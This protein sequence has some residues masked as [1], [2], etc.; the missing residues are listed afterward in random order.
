MPP[1]L[2]LVVRPPRLAAVGATAAAVTATAAAAVMW[3]VGVGPPPPVPP[4]PP[5]PTGTGAA[6]APV[7]AGAPPPAAGGGRSGG[8]GGGGRCATRVDAVNLLRSDTFG[9]VSAA[10]FR[11]KRQYRERCAANVGRAR[12]AA[13]A[14]EEVD[15]RQRRSKTRAAGAKLSFALDEEEDKEEEEEGGLEGGG[16]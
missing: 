9:L 16:G 15:A 6:S 14:W 5:P 13:A 10:E 4:P 8:G 7:W 12:S 2:P 3:V 1:P 11:A